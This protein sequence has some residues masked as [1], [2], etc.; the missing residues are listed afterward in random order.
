MKLHKVI[1]EYYE[2]N[3][4]FIGNEYWSKKIEEAYKQD[5]TAQTAEGG[6]ADLLVIKAAPQACAAAD[7][8]LTLKQVITLAEYCGL[9]IENKDEML[10]EYGEDL[11]FC[12]RENV[13]MKYDD[14]EIATGTVVYT[15]EYPEDLWVML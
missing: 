1:E 8:P 7:I 4:C 3:K 12:L 15:A 2:H 5:L 9:A 11:L 13:E 6:Q 10:R 14:G